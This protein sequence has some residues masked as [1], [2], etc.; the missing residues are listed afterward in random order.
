MNDLESILKM[1]RS[2]RTFSD[3]R[4]ER[5]TLERLVELALWAPS[6][7]NRQT[8]QFR[9]VDDSEL[10]RRV[11][12]GAFDQPIL[13]QPITLAVVCIDLDRYRTV[14][15]ENNLAPYLDAGLAMQNFLLAA[16]ESG[17]GS[18]VIAG[19][20]DQELIRKT[21]ALP[22]SW[23]VTALIALG[24]SDEHNPPPERDSTVQHISYGTQPPACKHTP[25]E[26][27]VALRKR[28]AR[29]GFNVTWAYRRPIE[30]LPLFMHAL[31]AA[32]KR[33]GTGER[34][35]VTNSLMG[36]LL[37]DSEQVDHLAASGDEQWYLE[38]YLSSKARIIR[39]DLLG[40]E[41]LV[42]EG[43]YDRIVSPFDVH[44]L[45]GEGFSRFAENV[46]RW[47]KPNGTLTI[48]FI[49]AHSLWGLNHRLAMLFGRDLSG[50]RYFGYERPLSQRH[51]EK[52]IGPRF[53]FASFET[54]SFLPP[55]NLGYLL[56]KMRLVP[57]S[58]ERRFD[59]LGK[60]PLIGKLGNIAL[61][62]FDLKR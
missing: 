55:P 37:V 17:I 59:F 61:M 1:R 43:T 40:A 52:R 38:T 5:S 24:H 4:I 29:A 13:H 36:E 51:I 39:A 16:S 49:N 3:G 15:L 45:G 44:F 20:L 33:F 41:S 12:K 54:L 19:R 42:P 8:V 6:S 62:D 56:G 26:Q 2:V 22:G 47:L 50:T 32:R 30:G 21:L 35:L 7:C 60:V 27:H 46:S 34:C 31:D 28:W 53:R 14:T 23:A 25:Y 11:A 18:C 10:I 9:F 58:L 48:V 57:L